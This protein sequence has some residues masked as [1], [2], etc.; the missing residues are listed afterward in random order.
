MEHRLP[1][2]ECGHIDGDGLFLFGLGFCGLGR[3]GLAYFRK[4]LEG[5]LV[6][7]LS[8]FPVAQHALRLRLNIPEE[9][10]ALTREAFFTFIYLADYKTVIKEGIQET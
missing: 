2:T 1:L 3:K 6:A 7:H 10:L 9:G 4:R 5:L 8:V